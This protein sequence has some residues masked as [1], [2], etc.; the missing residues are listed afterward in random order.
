MQDN[1]EAIFQAYINDN[2]SLDQICKQCS[3]SVDEFFQKLAHFYK[4]DFIDLDQYD[5]FIYENMPFSLFEKFRFLLIE[6]ANGFLI[7][8]SKPCSLELLEQVKNFVFCENM[9]MVIA[10]ELKITKILNQIRIQ[11][12][13]SKLSTKLR[14]EWQEKE[15][16]D[17]QSCISQIFDFLLNEILPFNASDMHIEARADDALIR[18]R[19]DGILHQLLECQKDVYEALVFYIKFLACLNLAESRKAQDGSFTLDF[20]NEKYDFRVSCLPLI[21]GESIVIRILKHNKAILELNKLN[22]GDKNLQIVKNTL[23]RSHGMILLTGP[24]GSGKSTTLYACLNALKS[25]EKKIISAEDPIEYKMP[26]VQQILLNS[27]AGV[28]FNNILRAILRQDPDIIMIGEIRDEES[29]DIALK[30]SLTGHLLLSTLHTN[31]A[32]S[33]IDRLLDM[34]AKAYLIAS[35]L[36]LIIAQRLVRKL[37][38]WCKQESQKSYAEFQGDFFE[39]K[40]CEYCHYSGFYGRELIAECLSIDE[41][42][43]CAI[44]ENKDKKTLIELAKK[45]GFTSMFEQ[46]LQKA[47]EG[48]TSID[49]LFRLV[50]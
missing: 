16:K 25:I 2:M 11:E 42:L 26:L 6:N 19:V 24:T 35:A 40:G 33:T 50:R 48:I 37:C 43:S 41:E 15:K 45:Q 22:L 47:K 10:N 13:M 21:Y 27:K 1:M 28:E 32:F 12:K 5:H 9:S 44:R 3:C 20:K 49:E 30:A 8:R 31:D 29:L 4:I 23:K 36:S 34:K 14:L 39:A 18:F 46:G 7:V 38:P 17:D